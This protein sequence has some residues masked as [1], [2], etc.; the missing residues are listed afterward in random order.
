[1]DAF[2]QLILAFVFGLL[3]IG[4]TLVISI[5]IKN[6]TPYQY[7]VFR[8]I[9]S[10]AGAGVAA[11]IPGFLFVEINPGTQLLIRAGGALAVFILLYF[12]RPAN[13]PAPQQGDSPN[14]R[15]TNITLNQFI[16][17][18]G[19]ETQQNKFFQTDI[20]FNTSVNVQYSA[21][22]FN[23]YKN[24]WRSLQALEKLGNDLWIGATKETIKEFS[25]QLA[26]TRQLVR[27]QALCF[28]EGDYMSLRDVLADFEQ[29]VNGKER[30]FD[31]PP[32]A[33]KRQIQRNGE[34]KLRYEELLNRIRISFRDRIN[35]LAQAA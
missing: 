1:M 5:I 31:L 28:D 25:Q 17:G 22:Q 15:Q 19:S 14:D 27:E 26:E 9:S 7:S 10:L 11:L 35:N 20:G 2:T 24:V 18:Q 30:L 8:M 33:M 13:L 12:F 4:L 23:A 29:F 16:Y 21:D 3:F 34:I 6:P 32:D